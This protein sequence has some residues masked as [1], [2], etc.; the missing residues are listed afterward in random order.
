MFGLMKFFYMYRNDETFEDEKKWRDTYFLFFWGIGI[1]E[2]NIFW[3]RQ[4]YKQAVGFAASKHPHNSLG[5]AWTKYRT[6]YLS[7]H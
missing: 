4:I 7:S 1:Q 2:F 3:K 5:Q 6:N